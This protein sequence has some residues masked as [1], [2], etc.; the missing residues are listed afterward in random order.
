MEQSNNSA[1]EINVTCQ[2][3]NLLFGLM[4]VDKVPGSELKKVIQY[5]RQN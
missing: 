1:L 5:Q 2:K 4:R 3:A